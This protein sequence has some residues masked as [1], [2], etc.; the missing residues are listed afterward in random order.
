MTLHANVVVIQPTLGK[1]PFRIK[2][3]GWL[4]SRTYGSEFVGFQDR[5]LLC[6]SLY[7]KTLVYNTDR[8]YSENIHNIVRALGAPVLVQVPTLKIIPDFKLIHAFGLDQR[9]YMVFHPGASVLKRAFTVQ[10]AQEVIEHVLKRNSEMH[11]VLSGGVA[12]RKF[13]EEIKNGLRLK[14]RI[15]AAIGCSAQE[16]A[17]LIKSSE[18]YL[19]IDTGITHLACFLRAR[20]IVVAHSGTANNWLPFYCSN[21]TVIYRLEEESAVHESRE[22]FDAKRRGRLKPLGTVPT[23]AICAVVD[24]V[25]GSCGN[26]KE[27]LEKMVFGEKGNDVCN[28]R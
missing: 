13:I 12:E 8:L 7:S 20:V 17:A 22:Y 25:V 14:E 5:G 16:I 23:H 11:V 1:I 26:E 28:S 18:F 9:R 2:L 19:G 4:I 24:S 21:A 27:T 10:A 3:L 6:K 15:V